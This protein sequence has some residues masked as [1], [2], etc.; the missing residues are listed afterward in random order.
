M[1]KRLMSGAFQVLPLS[2]DLSLLGDDLSVYAAQKEAE[3]IGIICS[4]DTDF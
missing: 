1:K 3:N 2:L 4:Q